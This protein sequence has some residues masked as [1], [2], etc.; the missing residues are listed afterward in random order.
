MSLYNILLIALALSFDGMAVAAANSARHVKMSLL[1]VVKIAFSFGL[2]HFLM[3]LVGWLIGDG[4]ALI[5]NGIDHWIAFVLLAGL[6]VK[7]FVESLRPVAEREVDIKN[8]KVL[9]LLSVATSIDSLIIGISFAFVPV[10]VWLA[11]SVIGVSIF[12]LTLMAVCLGKMCG[13]RW[14]K[15][16]EILG[17]L[18]LVGIGLKILLSHLL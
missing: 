7:M 1:Q 12:C 13:E 9:L 6:G 17:A 8:N 4:F 3:P 15:K 18:V 2:F 10:N 14:G 16:A 5:I 11:V